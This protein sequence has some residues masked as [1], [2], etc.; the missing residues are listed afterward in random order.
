M[1]QCL[2]FLVPQYRQFCFCQQLNM[3]TIPHSIHT[4]SSP[5][6]KEKRKEK[7]RRKSTCIQ[8]DG[9]VK[10]TCITRCSF[11]ESNHLPNLVPKL[12]LTMFNIII[13]CWTYMRTHNTP[14]LPKDESLLRIKEGKS[15]LPSIWTSLLFLLQFMIWSAGYMN[16]VRW[17]KYL[18]A[19]TNPYYH[20]QVRCADGTVLRLD[21]HSRIFSPSS[22]WSVVWVISPYMNASNPVN[23]SRWDS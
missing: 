13:T 18:R 4:S 19:N 16:H 20:G 2:L 10:V 17:H 22:K 8:W 1:S 12:P 23:L 5:K 21:H 9:I 7:K 11:S 3:H 15:P 14:N 6:E